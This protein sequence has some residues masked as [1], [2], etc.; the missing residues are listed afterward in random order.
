M[1]R[2][3]DKDIE[4]LGHYARHGNRELYWNYLAQLPGNDGY[5]L[6]ALGVVRHDNAP[7]RVANYYAQANGGRRL[8]ERQWE[9]FGIKLME[10]DLARRHHQLYDEKSPEKALNLPV[11]DVQEAH[12][13]TFHKAGLDPNA[14]TPRLL[15]QAAREREGE[16]TAERIWSLMLNN[17]KLGVPRALDTLVD[18]KRFM[19]PAQAASY[20]GKLAA[21]SLATRDDFSNLDPDVIGGMLEH[22]R[23]SRMGW[24]QLKPG[25]L[26][27]PLLPLIE[28]GKIG[29][30][31]DARAV[32]LERAEKRDDF[33]PDDPYRT[34]ARSPQTL[35]G[36]QEIPGIDYLANDLRHPAHPGHASYL[37]ALEAVQRMEKEIAAPH[38]NYS[39]QLAVALAAAAEEKGMAI[40]QVKLPGDGRLLALETL[41]GCRW[42]RSVAVD[43]ADALACPAR[44]HSDNWGRAHEACAHN[45]GNSLLSQMTMQDRNL[46]L[47]LRDG[48]PQE[49]SDAHVA[50]LMLEARRN[51]I[52]HADAI[53]HVCVTGYGQL[54][55]IE[56]ISRARAS[57]DLQA[58]PR[59]M[60]E[61][62]QEYEQLGEQQRQQE[63]QAQSQRQQQRGMSLS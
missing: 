23:H 24:I 14:W 42:Q 41:P 61:S 28:G 47:R 16:A 37:Q 2:L 40:H 39:T 54:T 25:S 5:G 46:F 55:V 36:S 4:I 44:Q 38:T 57:V 22:Y 43:M 31:N 26:P 20:T 7:G 52:R 49:A 8:S 1:S 53:A 27:R 56:S 50:Q 35:A 63:A 3:T 17:E 59:P 13:R 11:W 6:L 51:G 60:R 19:P 45:L 48:A 29:E 9:Q 10:E 21:A 62:L 58:E 30:L 12:D 34:L 15:L 32:R 18:I 33:H